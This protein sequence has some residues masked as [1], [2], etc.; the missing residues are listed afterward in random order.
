MKKTHKGLRQ[1]VGTGIVFLKK[2]ITA[3]SQN[4]YLQKHNASAYSNQFF[5]IGHIPSIL[6]LWVCGVYPSDKDWARQLGKNEKGG[7][8]ESDD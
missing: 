2:E 3:K 4:A 7:V 8:G 5:W 6:D 1:W